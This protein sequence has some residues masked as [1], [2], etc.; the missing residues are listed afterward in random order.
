MPPQEVKLIVP[1]AGTRSVKIFL[2][3]H[4]YYIIKKSK[5]Q[6]DRC[7]VIRSVKM[8]FYFYFTKNFFFCQVRAFS[9]SHF[10]FGILSHDFFN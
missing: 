8:H 3:H 10:F 4:I 1:A 6:P 2:L 7:W 9:L 5:N